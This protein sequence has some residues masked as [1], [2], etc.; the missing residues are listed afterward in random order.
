VLSDPTIEVASNITDDFLFAVQHKDRISGYDDFN[1]FLILS[2]ARRLKLP[3]LTY[4]KKLKRKLA[5]TL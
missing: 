3:L 5:D 4:D 1:D 2:V